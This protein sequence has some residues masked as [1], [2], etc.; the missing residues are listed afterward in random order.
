MFGHIVPPDEIE[1]LCVIEGVSRRDDP[2][3]FFRAT[4]SPGMVFGDLGVFSDVV[5][6][7]RGLDFIVEQQGDFTFS[8]NYGSRAF[9]YVGIDPSVAET[10]RHRHATIECEFFLDSDHAE[11]LD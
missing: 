6:W 3:T 4:V 7:A 1:R 10:E 9:G 2:Q 5:V 11:G 8:P